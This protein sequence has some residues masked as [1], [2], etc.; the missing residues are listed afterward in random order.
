MSGFTIRDM[1]EQD[2]PEVVDIY[3]QGMRT[4]NATLETAVP[5]WEEWNA[6][7]L[8]ACRS[9]AS[10]EE[11]VLGWAALTPVSGRC[12]YAGV[13][14]VSVYVATAA[15]HRGIGTTLLRALI[16]ASEHEGIWMLQSGILAEN[17]ASLALHERCGFRIVGRREHLGQLNGVWR[18][19]LLLERRSQ[20]VGI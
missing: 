19:V 11:R 9:I 18:D 10:Q 12:V 20:S 4:G 14:E 16:D 5:S 15:Q 13:A 7:H 1:Q 2:W 8:S 3:R 17:E 6:A